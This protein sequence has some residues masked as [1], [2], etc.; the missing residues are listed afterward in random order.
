MYVRDEKILNS[1]RASL[2]PPISWMTV[3]LTQWFDFP[4]PFHPHRM[5]H[6]HARGV[7]GQQGDA[8]TKQGVK[9]KREADRFYALLSAFLDLRGIRK[10]GEGVSLVRCLRVIFMY[11][12]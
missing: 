5:S 11:F 10:R 9:K 4:I 2:E 1:N 8:H 12:Y 7:S 3:I 6:L